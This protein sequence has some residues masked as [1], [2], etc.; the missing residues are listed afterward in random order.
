ME[1]RSFIAYI[2]KFFI[3]C[4]LSP[5]IFCIVYKYLAIMVHTTLFYVLYLQYEILNYLHFQLSNRLCFFKSVLEFF[6]Q[7]F[8]L[9]TCHLVSVARP[10]NLKRVR[11]DKREKE[12]I[13][14]SLTTPTV[15]TKFLQGPQQSL[16]CSQQPTTPHTPPPPT[17]CTLLV[18]NQ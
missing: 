6:L 1:T 10:C 5:D 18:L 8:R 3:V 16:Y 15:L 14:K 2:Y 11:C 7:R 4:H 9:H 17:V 12:S 13:K